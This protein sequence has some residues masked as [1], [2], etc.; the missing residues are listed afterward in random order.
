M[1]QSAVVPYLLGKDDH[2]VE[3]SGF[4]SMAPEDVNRIIA[5]P[6]KY[7]EGW[8]ATPALGGIILSPKLNL[9]I[10]DGVKTSLSRLFAINGTP[11][12]ITRIGVDNGTTN[13]TATSTSSDLGGGSDTGSSTQTL[14][15][16]NSTPTGATSTKVVTSLGTFNDPT[17]GGIGSVGFVMKRLFLSRH[18]SNVTNTTSADAATTLY[19]MTNVFTID[20]TSIS[21]WN[22]VFSATVT[23]AGT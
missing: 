17:T 6:S 18:L 22:I 21:T 4:A 15:T 3:W 23:G 20:F 5:N 2:H 8:V 7:L 9:V 14:R 12:A 19:S 16:F 1:K 13:P 10:D 11:A